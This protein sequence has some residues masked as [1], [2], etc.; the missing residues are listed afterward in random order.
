VQAFAEP[1]PVR[2]PAR[3]EAFERLYRSY[4]RDVYRYTLAVLRN[5]SDAEDITQTTF[6]NAYRA[7]LRG[8]EPIAPR[9]WLI[10]IAHNACR[11][12]H[13]RAVRRPQEVPLE[14]TIAALRVP[15]EE[16]PKVEE[17]LEA[18]GRLPFNQRAALV[19]RELEGRS[20][21]EIAQTLDVSVAAVETLIFR[22]RR[23]LRKDRSLFGALGAV[24]LPPSLSTLLGGG[25]GGAAAVA[26]GGAVA[27]SGLL[28][29]AALLVAT[30]LVAGTVG[31]AVDA[32][33]AARAPQSAVVAPAPLV[34]RTAAPVSFRVANTV[35]IRTRRASE[36]LPTIRR[37]RSSSSTRKAPAGGSGIPGASGSSQQEA[38][39]GA[40]E[41]GTAVAAPEAPAASVEPSSATSA[42][43]Q[44]TSTVSQATSD[45]TSQT[46]AVTSS[47]PSVPPPPPLPVATPSVPEVPSTPPL[48][49]PPPLPDLP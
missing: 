20:Y 17:L 11:T 25:G 29:K 30:G 18:L 40:A 14:E 7:Y 1:Q 37:V 41:A 28:A 44:T 47:L 33:L 24:Q 19:M 13:L 48:P 12:R 8:E 46:G 36:R 21:V 43:N 39:G 15:P 49:P 31:T 3:D 10:K 2:D 16:A 42:A 27:G 45:V 4:A 5:P 34:V 23:T 9:N 6:L 32:K 38:T 35:E 22:A 26:G